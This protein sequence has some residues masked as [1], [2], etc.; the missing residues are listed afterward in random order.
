M[1]S[2]SGKHPYGLWLRA[3]EE[4]VLLPP[5]SLL[6]HYSDTRKFQH[7]QAIKE[8]PSLHTDLIGQKRGLPEKEIVDEHNEIVWRIMILLQ[9]LYI[10]EGLKKLIKWLENWLQLRR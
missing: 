8:A 5:V 2:N 1:E 4:N 7:I 3:E 9:I 6:L 10:K